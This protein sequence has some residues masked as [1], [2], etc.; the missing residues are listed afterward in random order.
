M[1][2]YKNPL[3]KMTAAQNVNKNKTQN[4]KALL[5]PSLVLTWDTII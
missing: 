2:L 1:A 4:E 5:L 3:A